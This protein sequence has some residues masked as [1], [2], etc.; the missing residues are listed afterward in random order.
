MVTAIPV[1]GSGVTLRKMKME[2]KLLDIIKLKNTVKSNLKIYYG[3]RLEL[4]DMY[5]VQAVL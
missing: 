1:V 4:K 5:G 2:K 3:R